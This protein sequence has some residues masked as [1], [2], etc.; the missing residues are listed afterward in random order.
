MFDVGGLQI[1]SELLSSIFILF[2][3]KFASELRRRVGSA[4]TKKKEAVDATRA[5]VDGTGIFFP[6]AALTSLGSLSPR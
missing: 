2:G 6:V 1:I 4:M 5:R 3:G